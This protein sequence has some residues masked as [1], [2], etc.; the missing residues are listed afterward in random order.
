M[1]FSCQNPQLLSKIKNIERTIWGRKGKQCSKNPVIQHFLQC[2]E[3]EQKS[4]WDNYSMFWFL[5]T[6]SQ[7]DFSVFLFF[8]YPSESVTLKKI[9]WNL[10]SKNCSAFGNPPHPSFLSSRNIILHWSCLLT[11]NLRQGVLIIDGLFNLASTVDQTDETSSLFV[12]Q[13]EIYQL[14]GLKILSFHYTNFF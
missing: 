3:S 1:A 9:P 5:G 10:G 12:I 13:S 6:V 4:F 8:Y 11:L 2:H 14:P 7:I